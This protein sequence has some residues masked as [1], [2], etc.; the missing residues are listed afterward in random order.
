[1]ATITITSGSWA[2]DATITIGVGVP[3]V[4]VP[5]GGTTG[6]VLKKASATS[7]DTV[8]GADQAGIWG[9]ITGTITDQTDLTAY[10][11]AQLAGGTAVAKVL[12]VE[13]RNQTGATL[14]AGTIV[15][16]N[17]ATGNKPTVTKALATG[18]ATSAQTLG[19]VKA[20]IA[21][22][23]TGKVVVRGLLEN[24]DTSALTEGQQLYL[25][26]TT[27]GAWQTTKPVAPVHL[28]YVGIVT[29]AH[30]PSARLRS[31]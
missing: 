6:Q 4:G 19:F 9:G 7:Y 30:R 10:V 3:G 20:E 29:R 25:S 12:E 27:P 5:A 23:G 17:G 26:G 28:V 15:Y 1:M 24:V 8:W 14:T 18:D 16:I 31:P 11:A 13:V 22:N 2:V 21:N